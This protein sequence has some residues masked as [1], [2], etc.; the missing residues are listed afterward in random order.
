MSISTSPLGRLPIFAK[1]LR[2]TPDGSYLLNESPG[3]LF[4][5]ERFLSEDRVADELKSLFRVCQTDVIGTDVM[6]TW[7]PLPP[8][9][10]YQARKAEDRVAKL[11]AEARAARA[12]LE[13]DTA[14]AE[15]E[16]ERRMSRLTPEELRRRRAA[17]AVGELIGSLAGALGRR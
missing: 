17:A 13:R 4:S 10:G 12:E 5:E 16:Q 9:S 15:L 11:E 8:T 6:G 7:H 14:R 1:V 2:V 3:G